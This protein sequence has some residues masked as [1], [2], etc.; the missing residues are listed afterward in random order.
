MKIIGI[1][2]VAGAGKDLFFKLLSQKIK[3]KR[4]SLGDE[5]KEEIKPYCLA[6][7]GIDPTNCSRA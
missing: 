4:F 1:S 3:C 7:F 6:H 2:G 5:L